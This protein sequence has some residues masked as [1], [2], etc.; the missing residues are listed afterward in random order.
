MTDRRRDN[1]PH[2]LLKCCGCGRTYSDHRLFCDDCSGALLRTEYAEKRFLPTEDPGIFRFRNW[3]PVREFYDTRVGPCVFQSENYARGLGLKRLFLA[4]NGYWPEKGAFNITGSFKDHEAAPTVVYF[5]EKGVTEMVLSSV[6]NTARAFAYACSERGFPCCIVVPEDMLHRLWLPR[7]PAPCVRL[8]VIRDSCD[9]SAAIRLGEKIAAR[10]NVMTEGGARNVARRDGMS[11]SVLEYARLTGE[12]PTHYVQ[13]IG[14]G[15]GGIAAYEAGL[16]LRGDGRFGERLPKLHLVQNPPFAP[17]HEAWQERRRD[18][19]LAG[20]HERQ[21]EKVRSMYADVLANTQPPYAPVGGVRDA[22][23]DTKGETYGVGREEALRSKERF[24]RA[25]GIGLIPP[26]ACACAGLERA[27]AGGNI[28]PDDSI[29]LNITGG[30]LDLIERD[31]RLYK[32][33]PTRMVGG[34]EIDFGAI[35]S[36][37]DLF[38]GT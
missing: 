5:P 3:L 35:E 18:L 6:G 21:M 20:S 15:T 2:S 4:F 25:E 33:E 34:G 27:V 30:G 11:T 22:L 12:M 26:A 8:L 1:T 28:L 23:S 10:F 17:I 16:R 24:E 31:F 37:E 7:E 36:Y 29:L 14:S 32:L 38:N 13:A 19:E 9:Y